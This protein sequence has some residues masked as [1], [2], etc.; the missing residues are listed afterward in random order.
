MRER[1]VSNWYNQ[2]LGYFSFIF[3]E[4]WSCIN[5]DEFEFDWSICGRFGDEDFE[6]RYKRWC[7]FEYKNLNF[8]LKMMSNSSEANTYFEMVIWKWR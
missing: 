2:S 4:T 1:F 6:M 5:S 8:Y 3:C 7:S